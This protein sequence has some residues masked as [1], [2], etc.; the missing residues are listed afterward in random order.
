MWKHNVYTLALLSPLIGYGVAELVEII[1]SRQGNA[2]RGLRLVGA[3]LTIILLLWFVISSARQNS[4]FQA[5]WPD[6][7]PVIDFM[8][9]HGINENSRILSSG[10]AIYD[11]YFDLGVYDRPVWSNIWYTEYGDLKGEEAVRQGIQDCIFD[12]I[13]LDNY[14]APEYGGELMNFVQS[15]GYVQQYSVS[16]Q[17]SAGDTIITN[18]YF[19]PLENRCVRGEA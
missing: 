14:W 4:D 7:T 17:I 12:M 3:A 5:S 15:A 8:R 18:I 9:A 2:A 16:E 11:Y 13:V 10:Y 1:R 6:N 19:P